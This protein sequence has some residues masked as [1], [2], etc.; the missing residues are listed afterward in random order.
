MPGK[1]SMYSVKLFKFCDSKGYAHYITV[2]G[3]KM[4]EAAAGEDGRTSN[5]VVRPLI[6]DYIGESRTLVTDSFFK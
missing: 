1:A 6:K 3:G 4:T 2:F 5:V